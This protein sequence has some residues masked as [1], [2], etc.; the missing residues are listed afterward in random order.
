MNIYTEKVNL[1]IAK[2]IMNL[3]NDYL[4]SNMYDK[5]E[6]PEDD[7]YNYRDSLNYIE[8]VKNYCKKMVISKGEIKQKYYCSK[9]N[10][11]KGRLYVKGF[12]LQNI[13]NKIRGL[14]VNGIY[15]DFDMVN[16]A[17]SIIEY[18]LKT[19]YPLKN[20]PNLKNY[21]DNRKKILEH[22]GLKK[23]DVIKCIFSDKKTFSS[24]KFLSAFDKELKLI[25][26]DIYKLDLFNDLK[27]ETKKNIKGSYLSKVI[28]IYENKILMD[29]KKNINCAVPMFDGFLSEDSEEQSLKILNNNKYGIKWISKP[30]NTSIEL[31]E[32]LCIED[33]VKDYDYMKIEFENCRFMIKYPPMFGEEYENEKGKLEVN[34][35]KKAEFEIIVKHITYDNLL[36]GIPIKSEFFKS[37][38]SDCNKRTYQKLDW[39][40]D[41]NFESDKV[42]NCFNGYE[43]NSEPTNYKKDSVDIFL[44]H[45]NHL[46]NYN[47]KCFNYLVKY[48]AH[49]FQKTEEH[50]R[51]GLLFK[52]KQGSG[53][54][55][56][57]DIIEAIVGK[58]YIF[59]TADI[60]KV[61]GDFNDSM[62][63]KLILQL[64]EMEGSDGFS[65]KEKIKDL[66]TADSF[67]INPKHFKAF[68]AKSY[69]RLII[70][71]NN[72]RPIDIPADDRR[73]VIF[74][75]AD[76]INNYEYYSK[77]HSL[78]KDEEALKSILSYFK[79]VDISDFIPS[80][81]RP[82]TEAY[83]ELK[84]ASFNPLHTYLYETFKNDD[85][86]KEF[87]NEYV[88]HKKTKNILIQ[89]TSLFKNFRFYLD[90]NGLTKYKTDFKRVK[91]ILSDIN[92]LKQSKKIKSSVK[93]Y[94]IINKNELI[95]LLENQGF[96]QE[97]EEID[98]DDFEL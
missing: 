18:I 64:N 38:L 73:F 40:P 2:S 54:D 33:D 4:I 31:D 68:D 42:Y 92:I 60:K 10:N 36:R 46:V 70:F 25:Q 19:K 9:K 87:E 75:C 51:V 94:Y 72:K 77:L 37:W 86:K 62:Y 53:K 34:I 83:E 95:T 69:I 32:G 49:F 11:N 65:N 50:P 41:N 6:N 82:I 23:I 7:S 45:L 17:P 90:D 43:I 44:N 97:V 93:D 35:S 78:K 59:R 28:H 71:S 30:H 14:L 27:D 13:Q 8:K 96:K 48:W 61:F 80:E 1:K 22:Y 88:I 85:Y 84:E 89:S 56:M 5:D 16:A 3:D 24:N 26:E 20:Y 79:S 57:I 98:D 76:K 55:T 67:N 66:I 47:E 63:K 91:S 15:S 39:I 58:N 29:C 52:S 21:V 74:K 81:N 12:G